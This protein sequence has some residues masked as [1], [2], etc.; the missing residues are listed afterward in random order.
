M[1]KFILLI[2]C[3]SFNLT[4]NAAKINTRDMVENFVDT[5]NKNLVKLNI[6]RKKEDKKLYCDQLNENQVELIYDYF[7]YADNKRGQIMFYNIDDARIDRALA[8][9]A[10]EIVCYPLTLGSGRSDLISAIANAK[11]R[12]MDHSLLA[13]SLSEVLGAESSNY[14]NIDKYFGDYAE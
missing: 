4:V 7:T 13:D 2:L 14:Y 3:L 8:E 5:I 10:D 1:K 6:E 9:F 11:A 12:H